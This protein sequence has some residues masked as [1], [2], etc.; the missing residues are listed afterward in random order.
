[1]KSGEWMGSSTVSMYTE[2]SG[3]RMEGTGEGKSRRSHGSKRKLRT[4][5]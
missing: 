3:R 2:S 1:M 5:E 4:A